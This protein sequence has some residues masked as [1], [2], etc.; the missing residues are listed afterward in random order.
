MLS[1]WSHLRDSGVSLGRDLEG[2]CSK[3]GSP[4][5]SSGWG[6]EMG[7]W[8]GRARCAVVAGY[9]KRSIESEGLV[10]RPGSGR[11]HVWPGRFVKEP[12][13]LSWTEC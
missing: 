10:G 2:F 13:T 1:V 8:L 9:C 3:W 5:G 6:G 12:L 7:L 4:R 11:K